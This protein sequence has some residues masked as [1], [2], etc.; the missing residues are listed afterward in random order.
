MHIISAGDD[1]VKSW[2]EVSN[3]IVVGDCVKIILGLLRCDPSRLLCCDPRI[4]LW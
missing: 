1:G 2:K 3:I 4:K